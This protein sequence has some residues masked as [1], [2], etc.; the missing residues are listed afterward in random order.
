MAQA[1]QTATDRIPYGLLLARLGYESTARFR[2][3]LRPLNLGA[4][5][6]IVLKQL[7]AIGSCSQGE[8]ADALGID[9]S[10]LAGVTGQLYGRG[11][12]ERDRDPAD[13]RRY[14]VELTAEG[15]Q[16][17]ADADNAI[18]ADEQE[19]LNALDEAERAQLWDLLR[20]MADTLDI[21][22]SSEAQACAEVA[23]DQDSVERSSRSQ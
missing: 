3:S 21:C 5:E 18:A 1:A 6:F 8:L 14:V 19:M 10:N 15:Q 12:I 17:L 2:R 22:P 9:Y 4:Q 11:L 7:Q 16:L 20:R 13:K 23:A